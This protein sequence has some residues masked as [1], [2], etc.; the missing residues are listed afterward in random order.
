MFAMTVHVPAVPPPVIAIFTGDA[1]V[2]V[3]TI[4]PAAGLLLHDPLT[5]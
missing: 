3:K 4:W 2:G 5:A 1:I